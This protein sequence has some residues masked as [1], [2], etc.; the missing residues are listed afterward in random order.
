MASTIFRFQSIKDFTFYAIVG[1]FIKNAFAISSVHQ[2]PE[3]ILD[4]IV[5]EYSGI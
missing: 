2:H 4:R 1:V 3:F 5:D